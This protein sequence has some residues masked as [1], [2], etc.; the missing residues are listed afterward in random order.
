[1]VFQSEEFF[2]GDR[3]KS[4]MLL[5]SL[6]T[7][8]SSK[9]TSSLVVVATKTTGQGPVDSHPQDV[10]LQLLIET[11]KN[12]PS[13][14][15]MFLALLEMHGPLLVLNSEC[16]RCQMIIHKMK[17]LSSQPFTLCS[18]RRGMTKKVFAKTGLAA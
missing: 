5:V 1:M 9:S 12:Q 14:C 13:Q 2:S 7:E 6:G 4:N 3:I 17:P 10:V 8:V 16:S 18:G 11:K 15:Q